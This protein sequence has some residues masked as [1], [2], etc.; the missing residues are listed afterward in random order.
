VIVHPHFVFDCNIGE[1]RSVSMWKK[2]LGWLGRIFVSYGPGV[3][4]AI[5]EAKAKEAA[6]KPPTQ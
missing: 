2:F 6:K 5:M 4:E 3:V 1:G